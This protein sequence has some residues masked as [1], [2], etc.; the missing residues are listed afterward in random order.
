VERGARRAVGFV[1]TARLPLPIG[2]HFA[3]VAALIDALVIGVAA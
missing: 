2:T 3:V 1:V